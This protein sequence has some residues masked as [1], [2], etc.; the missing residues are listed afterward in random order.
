M[1]Q[2]KRIDAERVSISFNN[3]KEAVLFANEEVYIDRHSLINAEDFS[4]IYDS[5][6]LLG[7]GNYLGDLIFTPDFHKGT[8]T[9]IGTV[10]ESIEYVVP[11]I[12]G[13]DIGCGM[14]CY[15]LNGLD[16]D[17][18]KKSNSIF[19]NTLR[20]AF[21]E[22]GRDIRLSTKDRENILL[23]GPAG[24]SNIN[25]NSIITLYNDRVLNATAQV[26]H[27]NPTGI[28]T[29]LIDWLRL[30]EGIMR[31]AHLGSVGGGNHFV[32]LQYVAEIFDKTTAYQ[33]GLNLNSIILMVHSGSLSLG[34][35]VAT[36]YSDKAKNKYPTTLKMPRNGLI[37]LH[38][39]N[40]GQH[41]IEEMSAAANFASVNRFCMAI[42]VFNALEPIFKQ[43]ISILQVAN[44]PHN[45]AWINNG[46]VTHRKGSCNVNE[47][48]IFIVPGS[49]G[50]SSFIMKG[51]DTKQSL[52][53]GPHGAGR[54][55]SRGK[56][57]NNVIDNDLRIIGKIDSKNQRNDV[58]KFLNQELSTEA[59]STY[60]DINSVI[61]TMVNANISNKVARMNPIL[62][63]KG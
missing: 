10:L 1:T 11:G 23:E 54:A 7:I 19:D 62:T 42:M 47:N 52:N 30:N 9:P 60:K 58:K 50:T 37:P 27:S 5:F 21:F 22:G 24:L 28:H 39:S 34:R 6:D 56:A 40:E 4:E 2:F 16:V 61:S 8:S 36:I 35:A 41:Y 14:S 25:T 18:I 43:H 53:S 44:L 3:S 17:L 32:E 48:D 12:V 26:G 31:D 55:K 33:M 59:P 51:K 38:C 46:I 29:A 45:F 20:H 63:I 57:R 15:V 49:M 13:N